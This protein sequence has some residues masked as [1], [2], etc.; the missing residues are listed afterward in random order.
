[1]NN[2]FIPVGEGIYHFE[3]LIYMLNRWGQRIF[4]ST[5]INTG[6]DGTNNGKIVPQDI[7]VYNAKATS[8]YGKKVSLKQEP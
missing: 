2:V 1:M 5:D 8:H 7:Y 3:L 6:W 4:V